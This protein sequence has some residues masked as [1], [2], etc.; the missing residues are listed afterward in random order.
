MAI[1]SSQTLMTRF[2]RIEASVTPSFALTSSS[3]HF[4]LTLTLSS[5]FIHTNAIFTLAL[6]IP[7]IS[8]HPHSSHLHF[9]LSVLTFNS[10]RTLTLTLVVLGVPQVPNLCP[11]SRV[12]CQEFHG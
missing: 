10:T 1:M 6:I 5:T 7:S 3:P 11:L 9:H 4:S 12:R 2:L 8:P